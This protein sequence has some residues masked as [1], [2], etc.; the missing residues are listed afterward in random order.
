MQLYLGKV[1]V[2][3]QK[4]CIRAK[5]VVFG[6]KC[7]IRAKVV[8]FGQ[9]GCIW[10]FGQSIPANWLFSVLVF[11][12][13]WLCSGKIDCIRAKVVVFGQS[14]WLYL[15]VFRQTW[16]QKCCF[17]FWKSGCIPAKLGCIWAKVFDSIRAKVVVFGQIGC[18]W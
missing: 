15:I 12:Q 16:C 6:Q 17:V 5:V 13:K 2:L 3:G 9:S 4:G 18:I 10:V 1:V 7:C 8:V 14:G 11:G